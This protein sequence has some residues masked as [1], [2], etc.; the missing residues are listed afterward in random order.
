M[1]NFSAAANPQPSLQSA[2][3]PQ[4]AFQRLVDWVVVDVALRE[5]APGLIVGISGT[6]S[7]LAFLICARAFEQLGKGDRVMGI[8]YGE[9]YP[10]AD[11]TPDDLERI[12]SFSPGYRSIPRVILPWL[13]EQAPHVRLIVDNSID[14]T[15]DH[16]RWA[17]LYKA[18]LAGSDPRAYLVE[19]GQC[20]VVG[21]R[22]A[23]ED[24]LGTYSVSSIGASV[25][26][27][28]RL[29]KS[30]VLKI[31]AHL[32]VPDVALQSSRRIDC[33]CGRF[34]I[35]ADH[36]EEID[37]VLKSRAGHL[38][39]AML[40]HLMPAA[41]RQKIDHFIDEQQRYAG[42][43]KRIPYRPAP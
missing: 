41:L 40:D 19:G 23:T 12:L 14:Y 21:T 42:F 22:N 24:A 30:D 5:G 33:D 39:A 25:Q 36:I 7:I 35:A 38:Q 6:D 2:I 4:A 10:P 18:S 9:P 15:D 29:W 26:P 32:G 1:Q 3:D 31:C 34:D 28:I 16:A 11:K 43:K 13:Q 20:W 17:A 27:L 37:A 8:H